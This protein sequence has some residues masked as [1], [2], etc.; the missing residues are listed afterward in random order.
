M[1]DI[2]DLILI[3]NVIAKANKGNPLVFEKIS[4]VYVL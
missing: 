1:W 4:R 2:N 3:E